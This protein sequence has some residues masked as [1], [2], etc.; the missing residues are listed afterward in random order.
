MTYYDNCYIAV[1]LF[2]VTVTVIITVTITISKQ[3]EM[4]KSSST[5]RLPELYASTPLCIK[6]LQVK[7]YN[8]NNHSDIYSSI[9][10]DVYTHYNGYIYIH[11]NPSV[12]FTVLAA[13]P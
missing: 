6:P 2:I 5:G 10:V 1:L 9:L 13:C 7:G 4:T 3:Q 8:S 12:I 11:I